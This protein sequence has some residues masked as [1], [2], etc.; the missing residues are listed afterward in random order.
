MAT[1]SELIKRWFEYA[2]QNNIKVGKFDGRPAEDSDLKAFLISADIDRTIVNNIVGDLDLQEPEKE[3]ERKLS[4]Q[5]V[6]YLNKAK[7]TIKSL[8]ATQKKQLYREL[9]ND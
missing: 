7:S 9:K 5:E 4:D 6:K 3:V 1:S 8:S 2:K